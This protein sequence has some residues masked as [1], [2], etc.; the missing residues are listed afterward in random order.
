MLI[1][2]WK[3]CLY[4]QGLA[5]ALLMHLSTAFDKLNYELLIAKLHAYDFSTE[6]LKV[7]LSYLQDRWQRVDI[8]TTSSLWAQLLQ[9]VPQGSALGLILFNIYINDIFFALKQRRI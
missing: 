7:L 1:E 9:E 5:G 8:N 3:F 4:K 6:A 2:G